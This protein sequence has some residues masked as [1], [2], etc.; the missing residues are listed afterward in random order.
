[1]VIEKKSLCKEE[2][3]EVQK[4]RTKLH[5]LKYQLSKRGPLAQACWEVG[6]NDSRLSKILNGWL[7]ATDEEKVS[8]S[9]YLNVPKEELF[10]EQQITSN[11]RQLLAR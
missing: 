9:T 5:F 3:M 4:E 8:I 6:I 2:N 7:N 11:D 10:S 1:M